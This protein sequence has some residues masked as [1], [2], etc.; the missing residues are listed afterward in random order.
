MACHGEAAP[1]MDPETPLLAG[2]PSFYA[3]TQ[4]FLFREGRRSNE[5]M[6]AQAK[7]MSDDD[8]RAFSNLIGRLPPPA[9]PTNA[10]D[11]SRLA[12]GAAL[13]QRHRCALCHGAEY[14]GGKQ[15][16]RLAH[17]REGYLAKVLMEFR[18]GKR[19]GYTGAM[20]EAVAGVS[21][22]ALQDIAHYLAYL[23]APAR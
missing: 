19:L 10:T 11:P 15:V 16:A 14:A 12:R 6:T 23:P 13:A 4:L 7:G 22:E 21:V 17:Q 2:Q 20:S 8:L 9:A 18:T 3:I 1:G 5:P